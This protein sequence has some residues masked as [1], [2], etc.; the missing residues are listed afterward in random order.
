MTQIEQYPQYA[1][2]M[3]DR[4][5]NWAVMVRES[6]DPMWTVFVYTGQDEGKARAIAH[7]VNKVVQGS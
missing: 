4:I 2:A 5:N 6:S 7:A 3:V 1:P